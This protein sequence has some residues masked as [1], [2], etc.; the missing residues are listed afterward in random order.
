[1]T[2]YVKQG[3]IWVPVLQP[4]VKTGGAWTDAQKAYV[5]QG[6]AWQEWFSAAP[7]V[8]TPKAVKNFRI[9][10]TAPS[11]GQITVSWDANDPSENVTE[12]WLYF[13]NDYPNSYGYV[14]PSGSAATW[15]G[16]WVSACPPT[17]LGG[18]GRYQINVGT[19]TQ[20]TLP[21]SGY[22]GGLSLWNTL[23]IIAKNEFGW[24]DQRSNV[25]FWRNTDESGAT[26]SIVPS[27]PPVLTAFDDPDANDAGASFT[28]D[29]GTGLINQSL[30]NTVTIQWINAGVRDFTNAYQWK[31]SL[32]RNLTGLQNV[33]V[34]SKV[35]SLG[36]VCAPAVAISG[37][38]S[39]GYATV[40]MV[41]CG[42]EDGFYGSPKIPNW[43]RLLPDSGTVYNHTLY[44]E[45]NNYE[46]G[47]FDDLGYTRAG[48]GGSPITIGTMTPDRMQNPAFLNYNINLFARTG[49]NNFNLAVSGAANLSGGPYMIG[50]G[51]E[52]NEYARYTA[53]S[54]TADSNGIFVYTAGQ[55]GSAA[56]PEY[57]PGLTYNVR[58]YF[59]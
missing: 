17:A 57:V 24:G 3:G 32:A 51:D 10:P 37:A 6:G 55:A 23:R 41:Y 40:G 56:Q 48:Y 33:L 14:N 38:A 22:T 16:A 42:V 4:K 31:S 35:S 9:G 11:S 54:T 1:M 46:G 34:G 5:K 26:Y 27:I 44:A 53:F 47:Q 13:A 50:Y 20:H 29:F 15:A 30:L 49:S 19:A 39:T 25:V 58:F 18:Y 8:T 43:R 45:S 52:V 2:G 28:V 36:A 59:P 12:Y 21:Y 7:L